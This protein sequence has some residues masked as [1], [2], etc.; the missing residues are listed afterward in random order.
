VLSQEL[1]RQESEP[2]EEIKEE[3]EISYQRRKQPE[4]SE[5]EHSSDEDK[6]HK[7]AEKYYKSIGQSR[8]LAI[9]VETSHE[10]KKSD[11][12]K[13]HRVDDSHASRY[14]QCVA[15]ILRSRRQHY[16]TS[17]RKSSDSKH[18]RSDQPTSQPKS[19]ISRPSI[20]NP[21]EMPPGFN[22]YAMCPPPIPGYYPPNYGRYPYPSIIHDNIEM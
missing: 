15:I 14:C 13:S 17:E 2:V 10:R 4:E 3:G 8:K 21:Q 18:H 9:E 22:P 16:S 12:K 5:E 20:P 6:S 11:D 19:F 1:F 7:Q